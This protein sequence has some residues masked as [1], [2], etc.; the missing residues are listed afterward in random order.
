MNRASSSS[1]PVATTPLYSALFLALAFLVVLRVALNNR[2]LDLVMDYTADGGSIVEKI[3][4]AFWGLCGVALLVCLNFRIDLT[5]WELRV[6]RA[7]MAVAA[8]ATA[9]LLVGSLTGKGNSLGYL[10]D[11]YVML[12]AIIVLFAFPPAWRWQFGV[13]LLC[14]MIGSAALGIVEFVFHVR[15]MPFTE[16]EPVFRPTGLTT[17]PL[18]FGQWCT[19][20]LC[21]VASVN[22]RL[23]IRLT[24]GALLLVAC[25]VSGARMATVGAFV[26]TIILF[27]VRAGANLG[28]QGRAKRRLAV[29]LVITL[30]GPLLVGAMVA[31]GALSRF[32]NAL[33]DSNA[34]S[35]VDVYA[36]LGLL[37]WKDLLLGSDI[38]SV[39]KLIQETYDYDSIESSLLVFIVQFGLI[40]TTILLVA[41]ARLARAVGRGA[42]LPVVLALV[43]F[44]AV[45]LSN[46]SLSV[47]SSSIFLVVVLGIAFREER[48][49][50][51][52]LA[53]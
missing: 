36:V 46:N 21:C 26:C 13:L 4:P 44:S 19:L 24:I 41:L 27:T 28:T 15:L 14:Y 52:T 16:G 45:A 18:E 31:A 35:R 11:T 22:W 43:T 39:R 42:Q 20:A 53:A 9:F 33:P 23:P 50:T 10:L 25:V 49:P 32:D 12:V 1:G 48:L 30:F 40:G 29:L 3:H 38:E 2:L 37:S 8:I 7:L 6:T 17:H 34:M 51:R 5:A 47:K